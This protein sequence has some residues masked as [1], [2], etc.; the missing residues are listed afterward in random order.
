MLVTGANGGLGTLVT[1]AFLEAEGASMHE[2]EKPHALF[3]YEIRGGNRKAI[4]T[5]QLPSIVA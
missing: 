4:R 1:Q 5:V 3:C 2:L